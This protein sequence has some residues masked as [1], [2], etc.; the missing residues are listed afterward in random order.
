MLA[1]SVKNCA[2]SVRRH[3]LGTTVG[4]YWNRLREKLFEKGLGIGSADVISM[5]E[6]GLEHD[7]HRE[8]VPTS[9]QVTL[10]AWKSSCDHGPKTKS[11][12]D[13]GAGLGRM[14]FLAAMLPYKQ[15]YWGRALTGAGHQSAGKYIQV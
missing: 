15:G 5:R 7:E 1:T 8:H 2:T 6:L 3:G 14:L 11:S 9:L 12:S 10:D 13:Y 4:L